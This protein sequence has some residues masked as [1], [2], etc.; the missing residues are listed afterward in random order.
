MQSLKVQSMFEVVL[1]VIDIHSNDRYYYF[2]Q[3]DN[4]RYEYHVFV[5]IGDISRM[6]YYRI[7][8]LKT[9]R[10]QLV[11]IHL[12]CKRIAHVNGS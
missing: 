2:V 3:A 1:V 7:I 11:Y 10:K 12:N 6:Q 4:G 8:I 5:V 9:C